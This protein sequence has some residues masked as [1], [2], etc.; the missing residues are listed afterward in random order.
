MT[1]PRRRTIARPAELTGTGLHTGA[2][3]KLTFRPADAGQGI[4]LRRVDRPDAPAIPARHD[5]VTAAEFMPLPSMEIMLAV[6]TSRKGR[7]FRMLR[8]KTSM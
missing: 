2:K 6:N 7:F 4:R 3:T 5:Q 8:M 1:T